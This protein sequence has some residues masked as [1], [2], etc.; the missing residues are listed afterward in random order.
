MADDV[1][2]DDDGPLLGKG[3]SKIRTFI[4][5]RQTL[6]QFTATFQRQEVDIEMTEKLETYVFFV[7]PLCNPLTITLP[8]EGAVKARTLLL[9]SRPP[10][11]PSSVPSIDSNK[12]SASSGMICLPSPCTSHDCNPAIGKE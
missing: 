2:A 9:L 10:P 11:P 4:E 6:A 5:V 3:I 8:N 1:D 12:L 7:G